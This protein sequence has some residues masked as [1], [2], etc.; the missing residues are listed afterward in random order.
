MMLLNIPFT[1][2]HRAKGAGENSILG[3][4]SIELRGLG[5]KIVLVAPWKGM[6]RGPY[7]EGDIIQIGPRLVE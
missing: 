3:S 7:H 5:Y 4:D 2:L 1:F 6:S